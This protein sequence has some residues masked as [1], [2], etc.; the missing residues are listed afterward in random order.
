MGEKDFAAAWVIFLG[1]I[2][3]LVLVNVNFGFKDRFLKEELIEHT[4]F[5]TGPQNLCVCPSCGKTGLAYCAHCGKPMSWDSLKKMFLCPPCGEAGNPYCTVCKKPMAGLSS[6]KMPAA[7]A[8][9]G[10]PVP[11]F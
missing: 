5:R 7:D 3:C 10:I 8:G 6:A 1:A 9:T 11:V 2:A 4:A